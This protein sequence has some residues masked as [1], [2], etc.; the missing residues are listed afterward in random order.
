M[1]YLKDNTAGWGRLRYYAASKI[2]YSRLG[3]G[4]GAR[5]VKC[6]LYKHGGLSLARQ[7]E[8]VP[9]SLM[10]EGQ[11]QEDPGAQRHPA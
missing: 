10:L 4:G 6:L 1:L 2:C 5:W 7:H 9:V 11:S 8:H 3:V